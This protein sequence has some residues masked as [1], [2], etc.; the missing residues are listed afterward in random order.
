[1]IDFM[2]TRTWLKENLLKL[3]P[4]GIEPYV[5]TK[6]WIQIWGLTLYFLK[7]FFKNIRLL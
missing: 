7:T 1:M 5:W 2:I 4:S 6:C 3:E